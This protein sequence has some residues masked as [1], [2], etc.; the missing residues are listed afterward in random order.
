MN[1]KVV[2]VEILVTIMEQKFIVVHLVHLENFFKL[3]VSWIA[4]ATLHEIAPLT[5]NFIEFG[6]HDQVKVLF[7][8][9]LF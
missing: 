2:K 4:I 7:E 5:P 1:T 8:T 3:V 9:I 6:L